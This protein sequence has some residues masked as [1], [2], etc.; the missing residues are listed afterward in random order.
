MA[1]D[2]W[3]NATDVFAPEKVE[4]YFQRKRMAIRTMEYKSEEEKP[5]SEQ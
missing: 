2:S 5:I 3:E 1:H 4:E